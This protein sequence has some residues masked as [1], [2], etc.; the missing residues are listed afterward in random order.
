MSMK[1]TQQEDNLLRQLSAI[2]L[3]SAAIY[4]SYREV[5]R[6]GRRALYSSA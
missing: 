6:E 5:L 1:W 2:G 3:S 4:K